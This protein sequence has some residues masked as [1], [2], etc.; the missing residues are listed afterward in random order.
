MEQQKSQLGEGSVGKL[1]M[2]LAIPAIVAQL[3]NLLYN[4]VDRI[5]IGHIEGIGD[6][7]LTG[8]G[9]CFPL[10]MIISAF[11]ALVGMGS[12][13]R[14]SIFMGKG[15]KDSA[16]KI[17]GNSFILLI[18]ISAVLTVIFGIFAE[19]ILLTFGASEN[20][21][22]MHL[23]TL[24]STALAQFLFSLHLVLMHL[25]VHRALQKSVCLLFL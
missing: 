7:A 18:I 2:K 15:D 20:T 22:D 9:V 24:I 4:M 6:L 10:I 11:A 16:E 14:A 12:A 1:M 5:F 3:V 23:I 8:V 25:S 13:P 17:L 19:P 21:M